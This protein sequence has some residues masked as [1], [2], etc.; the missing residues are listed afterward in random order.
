MDAT[1]QVS[2]YPVGSLLPPTGAPEVS[3]RGLQSDTQEGDPDVVADFTAKN[4]IGFSS[5]S[6]PI[7]Q[8]NLNLS[9]YYKNGS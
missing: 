4:G 3:G 1:L 2:W 5:L 7:T 9:V 6:L 8:P